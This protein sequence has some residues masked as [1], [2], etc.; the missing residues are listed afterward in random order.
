MPAIGK[1]K[2]VPELSISWLRRA[3]WPSSEKINVTYGQ[4]L[5]VGTVALSLTDLVNNLIFTE[6]NDSS[7]FRKYIVPGL[8]A[9]LGFI[10]LCASKA[11]TNLL[12]GESVNNTSNIKTKVNSHSRQRNSF[13]DIIRRKQNFAHSPIPKY[14]DG[15]FDLINGYDPAPVH[16]GQYASSENAYSDSPDEDLSLA[17]KPYSDD[18]VLQFI[19]PEGHGIGRALLKKIQEKELHLNLKAKNN[20][21][22]T[23]LQDL[24]TTEYLKRRSKNSSQSKE[25]G[26]V[27]EDKYLNLNYFCKALGIPGNTLKIGNDTATRLINLFKLLS[28][29][30][31]E[32]MEALFYKKYFPIP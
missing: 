9:F 20:P 16:F 15:S 30:Q 25:Q 31:Y 8:F 23:I 21:E 13:I 29:D 11:S 22:V 19:S 10:G 18:T 14:T 6:R 27:L 17:E 12:A 3:V 26:L 28:K 1:I 4:V 32:K 24:L 2:E 5:G 7:Y